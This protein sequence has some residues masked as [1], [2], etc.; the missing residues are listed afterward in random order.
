MLVARTVTMVARLCGHIKILYKALNVCLSG[1][2]ML[3]TGINPPSIQPNAIQ[4]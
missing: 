3:N 4:A 1:Q 2:E